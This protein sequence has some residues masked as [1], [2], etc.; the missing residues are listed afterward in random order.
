LLEVWLLEVWLLA[1]L[2]ATI[3]AIIAMTKNRRHI[4]ISI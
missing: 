2:Q 1:E 4:L 3:C